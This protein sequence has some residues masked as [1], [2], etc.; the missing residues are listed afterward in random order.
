MKTFLDYI[1]AESLTE[2]ELSILTESLQTVWTDELEAKVDAAIE[3]FSATYKKADGSYDIN[4][5]NEELTN[6]GILGSIFGG[7]AGF[8]LG[9]TV[10][11]TIANILGIRD[12]IMY[13]MLTSRLVGAALGSALG[14]RI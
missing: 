5:F 12:G 11:K 8:A 7:L 4:A 10:G 2:N 14:S 9:K 3:E 6:E 1:K 13:E